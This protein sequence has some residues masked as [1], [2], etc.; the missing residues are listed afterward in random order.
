MRSPRLGILIAAPAILGSVLSGKDAPATIM[1]RSL[2]F[3]A[4][5]VLT[6]SSLPNSGCVIVQARRAEPLAPAEPFGFQGPDDLS[7][8]V[9]NGGAAASPPDSDLAVGPHP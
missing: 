9:N 4:G 5:Q 7:V 1:S 3:P 6:V 2:T 8:Y